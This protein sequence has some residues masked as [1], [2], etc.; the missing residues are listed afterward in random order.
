MGSLRICYRDS[1]CN[2]LYHNSPPSKVRFLYLNE[3]YLSKSQKVNKIQVDGGFLIFSQNPK[4]NR[5]KSCPFKM[6]I[7]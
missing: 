5:M 4:L 3:R 2:S 7:V 6:K 1:D